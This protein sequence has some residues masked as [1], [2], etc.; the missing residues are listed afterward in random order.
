MI[1]EIAYNYFSIEQCNM[2]G[3]S[4]SQFKYL[5]KRLNQS[6]GKN[7]SKKTGITASV[8]QCRSCELIFS[9]PQPR[10]QNISDHYGVSPE[11]YWREDYFEVKENYFRGAIKWLFRLKEIK[12]GMKYL[13]IGAG[14]GK[15]MIALQRV[16]FDVYGIEPSAPFREAAITRMKIDAD[17]IKLSSIEE[18]EY[19]KD[20]FDFI[21]FGAVLEHIY[22]PSAAIAKAMSWLKPGGIIHA[23][24]PHSRWLINRMIN[25]YY[26]LRGMDFVANISPM[27]KPYHMHEFSIRSFE[28]NAERNNYKVKDHCIY[29]CETF[30]PAIIDPLLKYYMKKTS[31]GMQLCIW[32]EK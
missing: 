16:G 11:K 28:K 20:Y 25:R 24:V 17:R 12:P 15:Q 3:A 13:D 30:M 7:P 19:E 18:A 27:H 29:V 21:S 5:G 31:T 14:I 2:C 6:Q 23:E 26:K 22:D 10:P 1:K 4:S 32:L 9:N 8:F